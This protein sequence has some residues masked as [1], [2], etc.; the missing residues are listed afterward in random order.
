MEPTYADSVWSTFE[1]LQ[2]EIAQ[3]IRVLIGEEQH[4]PR[5]FSDADRVR[6]ID[7]MK[8]CAAEHTDDITRHESWMRMHI[9]AGWQYG[10][11]LKPSEKKHPNLLP[12][13][14]LPASVR[15]KAKIFSL[16]AHAAASVIAAGE[17]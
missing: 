6:R 9:D 7:A 8:K 11:E 13:E 12:W 15:S 10:P 17:R 16:I 1:S 5:I 2:A 4:D 3:E 14:Q